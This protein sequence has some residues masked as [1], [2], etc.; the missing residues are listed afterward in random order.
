MPSI[1]SLRCM[2]D[3]MGKRAIKDFTSWILTFNGLDHGGYTDFLKLIS[4]IF[5][6]N[7][8]IQR[9]IYIWEMH[10]FYQIY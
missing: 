4:V 8:L 5:L 10:F 2:N 9:P 3:I 6:K 1:I 7:N